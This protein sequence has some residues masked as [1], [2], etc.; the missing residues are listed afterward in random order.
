VGLILDSSVAIAAERRG[1][2]VQALL[3]RIVDI[4]GNQEAALSTAGVVEL[5]HGIHRANTAERRARREAFVEDLLAAVVVYP[6]TTD[7]ARMAGK[8][9]AEQQS[10]G[11]V[12]PFADLP[13]GAT[14]LSLDYSVLTTN[15]RH[16]ERIPGLALLQL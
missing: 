3:Q 2:S 1:D 12:I 8:L 14:A 4:A 7:I 6:L 11:V 15:L 10:R 9:D 16:F 13:I 5:V